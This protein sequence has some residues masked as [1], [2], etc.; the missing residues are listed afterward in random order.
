MPVGVYEALVTEAVRAGLPSVADLYR[1]ESVDFPD[2]P[3]VLAGHIARVLS[4]VLR[5]LGDDLPA[6]VA[7]SNNLIR[8]ALAHRPELTELLDELIDDGAQRLMEILRPAL[9]PLGRLEASPRPAV[10]LS[11]NALLVSSQQ[12]PALSAELRHELASADSVSLLC[13]FV[14]WSGIRVLLPELHAA[15]ARAVPVRVITTTYTGSTEARALDELRNLGAEIKVSYDLGSTRLHAKAWLF[16]RS[17]G[18]STAYI[19]SSNVTHTALHDGLEWNVRLS[20]VAAPELLARFRAAFETYWADT[21]FEPYQKEVFEDAIARAQPGNQPSEL[22]PFDLRPYPFQE[23]MLYTLEVERKRF[24]RWRNLIVAATGTGKT[25][26]S[27]FDYQRVRDEWGDA[28]L[29]FVAHRQEILEQSLTTFRNVLRDGSFG[30]LMVAGQQPREGKHVFASV[31]SLS[32]LL[33]RQG[34]GFH[35]EAFDV[36]V[37]DEFHHAEAPTYRAL[38]DH[39]KPR[40]LVGMTATPERTD[41]LDIKRW[42]GGHI[43]VELRLWDALEQGLLC[44]FQYFGIADGTDL[45]SLRWSRGGYETSQLSSL[46]TGDDMRLGKVIRAVRDVVLDPVRMRALGFCVSI[47]HARYMADRFSAAGIPAAHVSA[48]ST[49]AERRDALRRLQVGDVNVLF[50]VDLFNE[51]LDIPNIDTVLLLRPT[52]SSVVF[53][54]QI[55]RGLRRTR[56]K[57]GLTILDF[58]GQQHRRFRYTERFT[59]LTGLVGRR[60]VQEIQTGFPYL[61]AGCS[62]NLDRQSTQLILE[63]LRGATRSHRGQ[64]VEELRTYG[65]CGLEEFLDEMALSPRDIYAGSTP[66]WTALRRSAGFEDAN[67]GPDEAGLSSAMSRMLHVDDVQRVSR[68]TDWLTSAAPPSPDVLSPL[69][70]RLAM[71]LHFDL[72][73]RDKPS[74][75]VEATLARLWA[76]PSMR[77]ELRQLLNALATR[78]RHL[79]PSTTLPTDLPLELHA[80][81]TRDE[82]LAAFGAITPE[83]PGSWREGVKWLPEFRTDL[84]LVTLNKSVKKFSPSTRYRDY[85]ISPS[86]FHWESQSVTSAASATGQRYINQ[87]RDGTDVLLFV[88]EDS[89]GDGIGA[90]PFLFLGQADYERHESE[91]PISIVWRLRNDMPPDFFKSARA[92]A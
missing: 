28:T 30:E 20:D 55:G 23:E 47:E 29:L 70:S 35:P 79:T 89:I 2:V 92:V 61:P 84:L 36:V 45:S 5:S 42:F 9:T 90:S 62:V 49:S 85:P 34:D 41:G 10:G 48:E 67:A 76:N 68:Y 73:L 63:N 60:L 4:L 77:D 50:A 12:E 66:G 53:M 40:L 1:L 21:N 74:K 86:L 56:D 13:A 8:E 69:E 88:R 82:I 39:V 11:Q 24:D 58:I 43:A 57:D 25:V 3:G 46:L 81:Y 91:R 71:M 51:G 78:A 27:A 15:R 31:Q 83:R 32:A 14:R 87:R 44:P 18:Y 75:S 33:R 16:E 38:L 52:E 26:V 59:A 80:R 22:L 64:L 17:S 19:G 54:Q 7:L 6:Q 72:Q 37:V 65:D